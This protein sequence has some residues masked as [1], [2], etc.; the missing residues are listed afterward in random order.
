MAKTR[1]RFLK[2]AL[3]AGFGLAVGGSTLAGRL[4]PAFS[5]EEVGGGSTSGG[6]RILILGGTRFLGPAIVRPALDRGHTVTL[7]NRGKTNPGLFPDLET[8]LGD[9]DGKLDA[10]KDREWDAVVDTSGYVPRVVKMSAE[11]LA[12]RV[13]QYVFISSISV[14]AEP[15]APG[16]DESARLATMDDPTDEEVL[17]NYGALKA[18]CEKEASKAFPDRATNIR[19]GLI[20]GPEDGS[21]RFTYWPVR[22]ARGGEVLAPGDGT[23][24]VQIIDVRD[25]GAWIV[26]M[27]EG[28]HAGTFNATGPEKPMTMKEMLD[29][30]KKGVKSD[31]K[32]VW[33]PA[34]FLEE[35]NVQAWSD[36]PVWVPSGT[37]SSGMTQVDCS[38]AIG[39][40]LTFRPVK[41]TAADTLS[42]WRAEP[43]ER[44]AKLKAGLSAER[45]IEVLSALR[46]RS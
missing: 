1:R 45:E 20:V 42:W 30:C 41:Q 7:F 11:L 26:K 8:L 43:E 5:K 37:D 2:T 17:K 38:R 10:L 25:L 3:G 31:A 12:P 9:R 23:D 6:K 22:L 19:P 35:Q 14:Y 32:L 28:G 21:D 34:K 44:R 33:A 29:A 39:K 36:M 15:I 13:K 4:I 27:V 24:K 46:S 18:L 16:A 40:G